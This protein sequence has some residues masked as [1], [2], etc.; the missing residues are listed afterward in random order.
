MVYYDLVAAIGTEGG[1]DGLGNGSAGIDVADDSSIF[2]VVAGAGW[3][4]GF[5]QP[6]WGLR[7]GTEGILLVALLEEPGVRGAG[8]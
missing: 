1:L 5:I 6:W 8:Y 2:G 4:V 3:L 7:L